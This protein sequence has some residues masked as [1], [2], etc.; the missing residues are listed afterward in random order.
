MVKPLLLLTPCQFVEVN[1]PVR[2]PVPK[3]AVKAEVPLTR[4]VL[5]GATVCA[6]V[7]VPTPLSEFTVVEP[8]LAPKPAVVAVPVHWPT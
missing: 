5:D 8:V 6:I 3:F 4:Q 1:L 7:V 2:V